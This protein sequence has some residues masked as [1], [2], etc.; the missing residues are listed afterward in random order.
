M[1]P[2]GV[3][4]SNL[5]P[6]T[7]RS[8]R[9][10]A[11]TGTTTKSERYQLELQSN[12]WLRIGLVAKD[13]TVRFNNLL[14][15][16][17]L[18]SLREAFREL[19]GT[20]ARG[21]DKIT[22][23]DYGRNLEPNLQDLI[24]RIHKG[25]YRPQP[26][27][28]VMIPK[29]NGKLRPIA[30]SCFED[31]LV[32]WVLSKTLNTIYEPLFIP[33]SF[34][35]RE[36]KSAHGAIQA[37]SNCMEKGKHPFIVEIDF[38]KF[39]DTINHRR[40]ILILQK[41][42]ADGR[43]L[44]LISRFLQVGILEETSGTIQLATRGAPQGSVMSPV[45]ANIF[46]NECLDQWFMERYAPQG[47]LIVRYAD[48]AVFAFKT[49]ETALEFKTALKHR[50]ELYGLELNEDKTKFI[51]MQKNSGNVLDFL[52]FT[53]Y[54]GHALRSKRKQF[55][56]KTN[57]ESLAKKLGEYR[58][59]LKKVRSSKPINT[60]WNIT[61]AKLRGHYQYY[62]LVTNREKLNHFFQQVKWALFRGLNRKSQKGSYSWK[63]FN[64][65]LLHYPLPTPPPLSLLKPLYTTSVYE[66]ARAGR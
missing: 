53:F 13:K 60:I 20:K 37:F 45:L 40:M 63:G 22:K 49:E 27:R 39:F 61:A 24:D 54:W 55:K 56:A 10:S 2:R 36:R 28:R 35:F 12:Q 48:D 30:I 44:S 41:R 65:R 17:N 64:Q 14:T 33:T 50:I 47:A 38:A 23:R 42:I 32:E 57:K 52:G 34:G 5:N 16:I 25:S 3:Q 51:P 66:L 1:E 15:R 46:L 9:T 8:H 62:G 43:F 59:W 31:K 29:A 7:P 6:E 4:R 19:D 58:E 21:I 18:E 26:K 11:Q